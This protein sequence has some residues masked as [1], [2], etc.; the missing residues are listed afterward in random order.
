MS[1]AGPLPSF[2]ARFP[3]IETRAD[4]YVISGRYITTGG[5]A[6]RPN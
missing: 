6:F 1:E 3:A 4:R 5:A 2:A